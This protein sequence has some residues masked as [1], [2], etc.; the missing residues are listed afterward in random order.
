MNATDIILELIE[1][2]PLIF[3]VIVFFSGLWIVW[4]DNE[5]ISRMMAEKKA[6]QDE[7]NK[8]AR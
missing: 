8:R 5:E 7:R 2:A 4:R 3:V 1:G 6:R